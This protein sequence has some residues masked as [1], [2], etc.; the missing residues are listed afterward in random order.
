LGIPTRDDKKLL[1][2][3]FYERL[4]NDRHIIEKIDPLVI[5]NRYIQQ[6]D[7]I[8]TQQLFFSFYRTPGE[9][10]LKNKECLI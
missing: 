1:D 6:K 5:E 9:T 8:Y 3:I 2:E 4:K 7:F 10:R